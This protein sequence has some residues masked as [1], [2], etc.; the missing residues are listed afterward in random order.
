MA[1]TKSTAAAYDRGDVSA[2]LPIWREAFAGLEWMSL[3]FSP[4]FAGVGVERGEGQG[5][6]LIPGF[7]ASDTSMFELHA[8]LERMGY[9]PYYAEIGRNRRCPDATIKRLRRV[10]HRAYTETGGKVTVIGHSLGGMLARGMASRW[11]DTVAQVITLGSPVQGMKVH[12]LVA[13]TAERVRGSC[14]GSCMIE[15]QADLPATIG[16][17]SIFSKRDGIVDWQTSTRGGSAGQ[18]EVGGT[19]I[20]MIVNPQVY[21]AIGALLAV[22]PPAPRRGLRGGARRRTACATPRK[23]AGIGRR[24]VTP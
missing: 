20:G 4:V 22:M 16:E 1:H 10:L 24:K 21:R 6:L 9:A 18:I 5:V 12:P 17:T 11:P 15:L 2:R 13:A 3:H 14:N 7:M 23:R 19:H 8:W